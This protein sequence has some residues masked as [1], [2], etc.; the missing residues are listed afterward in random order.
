LKGLKRLTVRNACA[1]NAGAVLN[2]KNA[3][4]VAVKD[5]VIMIAGKTPVAAKTQRIM[6]NAI[7]ATV[8][9]AGGRAGIAHRKARSAL[10]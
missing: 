5:V 8:K 3:L 1:R 7:L 10:N 4:I 2:G 9:A 6:L